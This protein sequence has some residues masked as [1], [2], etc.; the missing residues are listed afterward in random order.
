MTLAT[1]TPELKTFCEEWD[2]EEGT[3]EFNDDGCI[4]FDLMPEPAGDFDEVRFVELV[5]NAFITLGDKDE[6][7]F[8]V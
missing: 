6:I 3:V 2:I 1:P 5:K 4:T 7:S 8:L